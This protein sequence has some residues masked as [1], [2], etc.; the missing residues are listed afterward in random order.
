MILREYA[1]HFGNAIFDTVD[2]VVS[3]VLAYS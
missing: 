2:E 3:A 1:T